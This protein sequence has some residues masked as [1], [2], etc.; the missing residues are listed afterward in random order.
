ME[1][2]IAP[3]EA[4]L[5]AM[6]EV[7]GPVIGI[8][9]ILSAVFVPIALVGGIQGRLNQQFAIT[10]A[11][12]V[13]ISA[14]NAL[15]LSPALAALLLRPGKK[16]SRGLASRFFGA[17]NRFF[18][19]STNGYVNISR[20]LVRRTL[21]S[22]MALLLV[23]GITAHMGK[24]LPSSFL[25]DEDQ[26][27]V[28]LQALLPDGASLQRTD[29]VTRKM[30]DILSKTPGI[31]HYATIAGFNLLSRTNNSYSA[32]FFVE[33][34]PWDERTKADESAAAIVQHLNGQFAVQIPEA[35]AFG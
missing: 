21:L 35:I 32:F 26:G 14:F 30:E 6:E 24:R 5:K 27:F 11:V 29:Q 28:L 31:E 4:A 8:A 20:L 18:E 23:F 1:A 17:F 9:L 15:S 3:K 33:L 34:K 7:A 22:A 16:E 25:P 12:S 19:K 10:I 2:G 13:L